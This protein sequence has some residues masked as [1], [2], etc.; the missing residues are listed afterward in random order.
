M[1][2]DQI[3]AVLDRVRSWPAERQ[4]EAVRLLTALEEEQGGVYL[5]DEDDRADLDAAEAEIARG[6]PVVPQEDVEA[7]FRRLTR[8]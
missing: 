6:D 8:T 5:L 3:E 1:T 2:R 7:A 4:E